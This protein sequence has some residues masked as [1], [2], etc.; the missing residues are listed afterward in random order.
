MFK[1]LK[2][3]IEHRGAQILMHGGTSRRKRGQGSDPKGAGDP[4]DQP[5]PLGSS[6]ILSIGIASYD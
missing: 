1:K 3:K 2:I 5:P 4:W 6:R